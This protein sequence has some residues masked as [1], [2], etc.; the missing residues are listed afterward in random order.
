MLDIE[1]L[2]TL[3]GNKTDTNLAFGSGTFLSTFRHAS[4]ANLTELGSKISVA[5]RKTLSVL[6]A[7]VCYVPCGSISQETDQ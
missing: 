5:W 4:E 3:L 6:T 7:K 2:T 1:V